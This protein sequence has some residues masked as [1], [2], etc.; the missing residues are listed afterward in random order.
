MSK[1]T[2]N[3]SVKIGCKHLIADYDFLISELHDFFEEKLDYLEN[4]IGNEFCRPPTAHELI[5]LVFKEN[6]KSNS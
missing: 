5:E 3:E 6:E 1:K 2:I 4:T